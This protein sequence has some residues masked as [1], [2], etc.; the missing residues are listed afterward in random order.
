MKICSSGTGM[1]NGS[2]FLT[3]NDVGGG[4]NPDKTD[5]DGQIGGLQSGGAFTGMPFIGLTS[6]STGGFIDHSLDFGFSGD[7]VNPI[8]G[9]GGFIWDDT[10]NDGIQD[11]GESGIEGVTVRLFNDADLLGLPYQVIVGE[12]NLEEGLVEF[13]RRKDGDLKKVS[14]EGI[15]DQLKGLFDKRSSEKEVE[16]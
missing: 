10:D 8:A 12:R 16:C 13:K 9:I 15:I 4:Q 11:G 3:I 5:S 2:L 7:N 14:V 1:L 6:G